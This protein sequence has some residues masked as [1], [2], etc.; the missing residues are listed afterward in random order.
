LDSNEGS[1]F[2]VVTCKALAAMLKQ[3]DL[4][5]GEKLL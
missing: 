2:A 3:R 1:T 4:S 5:N